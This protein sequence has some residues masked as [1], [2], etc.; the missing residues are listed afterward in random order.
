MYTMCIYMLKMYILHMTYIY[1]CIYHI[2]LIHSSV[3]GHLLFL[4]LDYCEQCCDEQQCA[5]VLIVFWLTFLQ[6]Y[7][8]TTKEV[9]TRFRRQPTELEKIFANYKSDKGL[10]TRIYRELKNSTLK[11]TM[12]QWRKGQM[13]WTEQSF[14]KGRSP[15]SWKKNNKKNT[16]RNVQ[17]PWP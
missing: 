13:N 12:T 6:V 16:W 14:F 1:I 15:N 2:F 4:Q 5:N 10:I 8:S 3:V 17:H 7:S 9:V 11:K